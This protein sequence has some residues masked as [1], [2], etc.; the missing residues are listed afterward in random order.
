VRTTLPTG[1]P[2]AL[3]EP[4][5]PSTHGLV[6]LPDIGGLRPLF[7]DLVAD[8]A[9]RTGRVVCAP[10]PFPGHEDWSFE[11]RFGGGVGRIGDERALADAVAAADAT[12]HE[13]VG[14]VGF[15][16]GGMWALKSSATGRFDRAVS[17]YGII[18]LPEAWRSP[19]LAE[20][21]EALASPDRCPVLE[22]VG[23]ADEYVAAEDADAA[24]ALGVEVVRYDGAEHGFV[25]DPSRPTHRPA[26]AADAW[27]RALAFLDL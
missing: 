19:G 11:E 6:V 3:A 5:G 8:L 1:T 21:L 9:R 24:E 7:D 27:R 16:M 14:V 15:C 22:L 17:F 23:T 13:A 18:R 20:P 25:H 4:E 12:G 26:D 2:A 10:E